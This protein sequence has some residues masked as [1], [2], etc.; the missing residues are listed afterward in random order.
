MRTAGSPN[1][2]RT[3]PPVHQLEEV[4]PAGGI[5]APYTLNTTLRLV[6]KGVTNPLGGAG[7]HRFAMEAVPAK[8][9]RRS[10][11]RKG[12]SRA[13]GEGQILGAGSGTNLRRN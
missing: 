4:T 1:C 11:G 5:E 12:R 6:A 3:E 8:I 9:L 7:V 13:L 10:F 2:T